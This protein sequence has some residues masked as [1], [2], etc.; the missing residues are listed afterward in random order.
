MGDAARVAFRTDAGSAVG[1]GHLSRCLDLAHALRTPGAESRVLIGYLLGPSYLALRPE[2]AECGADAGRLVAPL[3]L[4]AIGLGAITRDVVAGLLVAAPRYDAGGGPELAATGIPM[5]ATG[6]AANQMP[7]VDAMRAAGA[8]ASAGDV[9]DAALGPGL[10]ATLA[11]L[12][13]DPGRRA[14]M[15]RRGRALVD[16]RGAP[17]VARARLD[18]IGRRR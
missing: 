11:A 5:V 15:S 3:V 13:A 18:L 17:R 4:R 2:F 14:D 10:V 9:H 6:L 1:L 16:G 7:N 12:A 8:L